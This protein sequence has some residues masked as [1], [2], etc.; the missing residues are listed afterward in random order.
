[1]VATRRKGYA[2]TAPIAAVPRGALAGWRADVARF[3]ELGGAVVDQTSAGCSKKGARGKS[4]FDVYQGRA[5]RAVRPAEP[6][7]SGLVLEPW[8]SRATRP[9]ARGA[10]RLEAR[11]SNRSCWGRQQGQGPPAMGVRDSSTSGRGLGVSSPVAYR[12]FR[13]GNESRTSSA[14][15][16]AAATG[17]TSTSGPRS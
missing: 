10:S 11:N 3:R 15:S 4:L 14:A 9:T 5:P 16:S 2:K 17:D 1:M 7:R 12:R 13:R 8:S 6:E